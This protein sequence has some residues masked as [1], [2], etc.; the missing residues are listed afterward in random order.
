MLNQAMTEHYACGTFLDE[1]ASARVYECVGYPHLIVKQQK[2]QARPIS[3]SSALQQS[4]QAWAYQATM[5]DNFKHIFVPWSQQI[6]GSIKASSYIMEKIDVTKP[7]NMFDPLPET[8]NKE[9]IRFYFL[10][11][12][13]GYFPYDYELYEQ[14]D[15]KIYMVDFDKFGLIKNNSFIEFPFKRTIGLEEAAF[16]SPPTLSKISPEVVEKNIA[17]GLLDDKG[18]ASIPENLPFHDGELDDPEVVLHLPEMGK[19]PVQNNPVISSVQPKPPKGHKK[20]VD[21]TSY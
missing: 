17:R 8:I 21:V 20:K 12:C 13:Q 6:G 11:A 7:Y 2:R 9:L 16:W 5:K 3:H 14:P 10:A 1:G 19:E 4:I 15:G 18:L